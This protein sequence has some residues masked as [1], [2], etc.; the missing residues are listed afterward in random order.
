MNSQE[1]YDELYNHMKTL[2]AEESPDHDEVKTCAGSILS[3]HR[4]F[5]PDLR[6]RIWEVLMD[7]SERVC[8]FPSPYVFRKNLILK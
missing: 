7:V 4:S 3:L 2:L 1:Q 8:Q 6:F 5:P